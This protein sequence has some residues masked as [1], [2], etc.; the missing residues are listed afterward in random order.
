MV[1]KELNSDDIYSVV[2]QLIIIYKSHIHVRSLFCI[3]SV[4]TALASLLP[5]IILR[6]HHSTTTNLEVAL[7]ISKNVLK[8]CAEQE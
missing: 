8:R 5:G 3:V 2:E 6:M 4:P 1:K 7:T